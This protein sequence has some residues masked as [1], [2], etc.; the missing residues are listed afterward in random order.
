M[1]NINGLIIYHRDDAKKNEFF[2][3]SIMQYL[4]DF[5]FKMQLIYENDINKEYLNNHH[6]TFAIYRGRDSKI[7]KLLED[8]HIRVFNSSRVNELANDK[9]LTY[10]F[11]KE[12]SLPVMET[13]TNINEVNF[14][15]FIAKSRAGHGGNEV[16]LS[17][18]KEEFKN[19][20]NYI[21]Q[22]MCSTPG[23][24]VRV[25]VLGRKIYASVIRKS[26]TNDFRSNFSLG[27]KVE[28]F[29]P[30]KRMTK[31]VK[32][33]IDLLHPD[34]IGIDFI[35]DKGRWVINEIEDPVGARML[36]SLN[37]KNILQDFAKYIKENIK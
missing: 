37:Y 15:P 33:I 21:F 34:Y 23:K 32:K 4:Q 12:N 1:N 5:S 17:N 26:S 24:D 18:N 20:N 31:I 6:I 9:Y 29:H 11:M 27:G 10:L 14:L 13:F 22:R 28:K 8:H 19:K 3:S 36:Y 35:F 25:Y 16:Y 7:A 30:T 2:I